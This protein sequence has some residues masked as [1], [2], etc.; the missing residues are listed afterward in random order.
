MQPSLLT[1]CS[2]QIHLSEG[3][4]HGRGD[5]RLYFSEHVR[6]CSSPEKAAAGVHKYFQ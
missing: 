2:S 4:L 3:A 1:I 6:M 5:V